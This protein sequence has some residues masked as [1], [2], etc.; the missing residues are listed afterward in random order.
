MLMLDFFQWWY[1]KGF[2][3]FLNRIKTSIVMV[4][5]FF[6]IDILLKTF[7]QPFKL[8]DNEAYGNNFPAQVKA[9]ADRL[10]SCVFGAVI[11]F[12]T[13]IFGFLI[14]LVYLI[15][16]LALI[17]VW[18]IAP[19]LPVACLILFIFGVKLW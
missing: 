10:F 19:I 12:F 15:F 6:S 18:L 5:D 13:L 17:L 11:R 4:F 16:D 1:K 7:F 2:F 8:I 3:D 14:L 9:S